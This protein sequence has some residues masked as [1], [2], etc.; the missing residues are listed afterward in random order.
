V[1]LRKIESQFGHEVDEPGNALTEV[2]GSQNLLLY[3]LVEVVYEV[4]F[5]LSDVLV[6]NFDKETVEHV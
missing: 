5:N 3:K 2:T 1:Y 6:K 4:L